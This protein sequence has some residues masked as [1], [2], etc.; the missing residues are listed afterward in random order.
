[1]CPSVRLHLPDKLQHISLSCQPA[2]HD[3]F[4]HSLSSVPAQN[5]TV[6][7]QVVFGHA[8]CSFQVR[9]APE[10]S[11]VRTTDFNDFAKLLPTL[12]AMFGTPIKKMDHGPVRIGAPPPETCVYET[13]RHAMHDA[14]RRQYFQYSA[15][16]L[17]AGGAYDTHGS[18]KS[19]WRY[20]QFCTDAVGT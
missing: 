12:G 10:I 13:C 17:C 6:S 1:M 8:I 18:K 4:D 15:C 5:G 14:A 20:A 16:L 2:Q 9:A 7:L 11:A 19:L 3:G